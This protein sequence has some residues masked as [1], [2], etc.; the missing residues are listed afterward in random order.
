MT[1]GCLH[2]ARWKCHPNKICPC[3]LTNGMLSAPFKFSMGC[4]LHCGLLTR[5][6]DV[7]ACS[8]SRSAKR[9]YHSPVVRRE[10]SPVRA[11]HKQT[12]PTSAW[13]RPSDAA[14]DLPPDDDM[15]EAAIRARETLHGVVSGPPSKKAKSDGRVVIGASLLTRGGGT[16]TGCSV[17]SRPSGPEIVIAR[18]S[19]LPV[20]PPDANGLCGER[21]AVLKALSEGNMHFSALYMFSDTPQG[22]LL[23][24]LRVGAWLCGVCVIGILATR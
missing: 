14:M 9:G 24:V 11:S 12:R 23:R 13:S 21:I 15:I 1:L 3:T 18:H 10:R 2:G 6:M 19:V 16:Y 8:S 22:C 7:Y 4:G 17:H 5:T 20:V